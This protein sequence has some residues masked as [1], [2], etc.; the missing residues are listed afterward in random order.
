MKGNVLFFSTLVGNLSSSQDKFPTIVGKKEHYLSS[1]ADSTEKCPSLYYVHII[2]IVSAICLNVWQ[3]NSV[4][5]LTRLWPVAGPTF[6]LWHG[7]LWPSEAFSLFWRPAVS[8]LDQCDHG[9][10]PEIDLY[11]VQTM[12]MYIHTR[13]LSQVKGSVY[14]FV[15][16]VCTIIKS[17]CC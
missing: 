12:Y 5:W 4:L 8:T 2:I 16:T 9:Q 17:W 6:R 11:Y 14:V 13:Y 15:L 1:S 10:N 7:S 3:L